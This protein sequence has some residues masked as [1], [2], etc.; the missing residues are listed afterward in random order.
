LPLAPALPPAAAPET[1]DAPELEPPLADVLPLEELDPP[2]EEDTLEEP[3]SE[4]PCGA[5]SLLLVEHAKAVH[6]RLST[7]A[8]W[9]PRYTIA[10]SRR[11]MVSF[12]ELPEGTLSPR[13]LTSRRVLVRTRET[14]TPSTNQRP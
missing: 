11:L 1:D 14:I 5:A 3:A 8:R 2:P 6:T 10:R 13:S 9:T 12:V 4:S 7:A